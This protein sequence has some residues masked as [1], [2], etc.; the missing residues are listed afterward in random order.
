MDDNE[1]PDRQAAGT[2]EETS[3]APRRA[4][5]PA[6][7]DPTEPARV[8]DILRSDDKSRDGDHED[9]APTRSAGV[10]PDSDAAPTRAAGVPEQNDD[11]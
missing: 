1:R 4:M 5:P 10:S 8:E 7:P 6:E 2:P 9:T 11:A 3:T